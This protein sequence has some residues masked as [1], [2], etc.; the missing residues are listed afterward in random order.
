MTIHETIQ[1]LESRLGDN[2]KSLVFAHLADLYL[3]IERIDEAI[4]LCIE[5]LKYHPTYITSNFI[6]G[7]AYLAKNDSEN[8][9]SEFKKVLSHDRQ[10]LA[11]HKLL[12]DLMAKMGWENKAALHYRD[13]LRIDPLE[14]STRELL[15]MY[16]FEEET[17]PPPE[18]PTEKSV[19]PNFPQEK[20]HPAE[21]QKEQWENRLE[22][23]FPEKKPAQMADEKL[24]TP[25]LNIQKEIG[26][27]I[28]E[29]QDAILE[30]DATNQDLEFPIDQ[31][32]EFPES[33]S[34]IIEDIQAPEAVK[35]NLDSSIQSLDL[36]EESEEETD[37]LAE[38]DHLA[39]ILIDDSEDQ[40]VEKEVESENKSISEE[41]KN[42]LLIT[43]E[44]E[45]T[46]SFD[47]PMDEEPEKTES[48]DTA[49]LVETESQEDDILFEISDDIFDEK[50]ND[51]DKT[52]APD[53]SSDD[54]EIS[55][56]FLDDSL[57]EDLKGTEINME[58]MSPS[59]S[60]EELSNG[61][62]LDISEILQA[63]EESP[64]DSSREEE[65]E[66][67]DAETI[68]QEDN[69]DQKISEIEFNPQLLN[70][71]IQ[72]ES[73]S[74]S[75]SAEQEEPETEIEESPSVLLSEDSEEDNSAKQEKPPQ[76]SKKN[77][78]SKPPVEVGSKLKEK[79]KPASKSKGSD[80]IV[81]PTLGEIYAA[82]GQYSKAIKVYE[83][84]IERKP[85]DEKKYR[86]KIE[87]LKQMDSSS[88]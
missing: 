31:E 61:E 44:S 51:E 5:G 77:G 38:S 70:Y 2:P 25:A 81:S 20:P 86:V 7:K 53:L 18:L 14:E 35:K 3:T 22:E 73:D 23:L 36:D 59:Y 64:E 11:A 47:L 4:A 24:E 50:Q 13:I 16:P 84:L 67:I 1:Y 63:E 58:E 52:E 37:A 42:P 43:D 10:Y 60:P 72:T 65:T 8:A 69:S 49:G 75:T 76:Q 71:S 9:E 41:D 79:S 6:L 40:S 62:A 28:Q 15:N 27:T 48:G 17:L 66:T 30:S 19:E 29:A 83:N 87:E 21:M 26:Q 45:E 78:E 33:E 82:Q 88:S 85:D 74:Q 12:G 68:L 56:N 32:S 54:A 46:F 57:E 39:A 55:L 80:K 34:P